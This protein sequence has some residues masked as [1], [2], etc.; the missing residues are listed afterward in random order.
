V[1][2]RHAPARVW[3]NLGVACQRLHHY[4]DAVRAFTHAAAMPD[5]TLDMQRIGQDLETLPTLTITN[6]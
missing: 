6:R 4:D 2:M 5:A 1:Q 3:Y